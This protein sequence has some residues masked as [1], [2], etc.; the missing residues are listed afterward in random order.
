[1]SQDTAVLRMPGRPNFA[2][3]PTALGARLMG[4]HQFMRE[5]ALSKNYP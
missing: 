2:R 4:G 5:Y 3:F 1:L